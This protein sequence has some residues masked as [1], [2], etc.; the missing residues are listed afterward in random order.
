MNK[1]EKEIIELERAYYLSFLP[2]TDKDRQTMVSIIVEYAPHNNEINLIFHAGSM[3]F[4]NN[5][6]LMKRDGY[7]KLSE[8]FASIL[9][10]Y[11]PHAKQQDNIVKIPVQFSNF[12]KFLNMF[13]KTDWQI[14]WIT[15]WGIKQA[16]ENHYDLMLNIESRSFSDDGIATFISE[17]EKKLKKHYTLF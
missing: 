8:L 3:V 5:F 10:K 9:V 16:F 1:F 11:L 14:E 7:R 17:F 15:K 2:P 12:Y 4:R 6:F 13:D